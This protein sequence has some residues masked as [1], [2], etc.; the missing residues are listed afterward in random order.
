[1]ERKSIKFAAEF[2]PDKSIVTNVNDT[3]TDRFTVYET[4]RS[5]KSGILLV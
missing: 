1:M 5:L 4:I 3:H 2:T